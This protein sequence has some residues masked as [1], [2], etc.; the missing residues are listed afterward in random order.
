MRKMLLGMAM[1]TLVAG[2]ALAQY[3]EWQVRVEMDMMLM[4]KVGAEY[5]FNEDWGI[6]GSVGVQPFMPITVGYNLY[7]VYHM[8]APERAFQADLYL[9][10]PLGYFNLLEGRSVDWDPN[11]D[12]PYYGWILGGGI[13][14]SYN[15][16]GWVAGLRT[17]YGTHLEY[18]SGERR[19]FRPFPEFAIDLSWL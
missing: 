9:G 10:A 7:G 4:V 17:G 13:K 19:A 6:Q 14:W 8:L 5:R 2:M 12:E 1:F 3:P 16:N 15:F 11:I 18:A